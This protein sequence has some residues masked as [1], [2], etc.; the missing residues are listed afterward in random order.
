MEEQEQTIDLM[1]LLKVFR[2]NLLAIILVTILAGAAGFCLAYFVIPKR[3]TAETLMYVENSAMKSEDSS[4]NINDIN[5]A[6]KLVNTCQIIF[7]SDYILG[8]LSNTFDG[9]YSLDELRKIVTVTAVNNTEV[10]KISIVTENPQESYD[11]TVRLAEL[12]KSEFERVLENGSIKTISDPLYPE[13]HTYPSV[14]KFTAA[15]A[16]LGLFLSYFT[17]IIAEMLDIKIK[18]GD[19]LA[20]MYNIPVFAE[21]LDFRITNGTRYADGSGA[22]KGYDKYGYY[23]TDK[24]AEKSEKS[25]K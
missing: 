12:A 23:S 14:L 18:P 17:F 15:A 9:R 7:T 24:S 16:V 1:E 22:Y 20:A 21:I 3:Y 13:K 10:V 25:K 4:I 11:L 8:E 6:Q 5:A 19:D 2:K